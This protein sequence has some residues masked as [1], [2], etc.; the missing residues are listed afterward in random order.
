MSHSWRDDV[1]GGT[2]HP[3]DPAAKGNEG[4]RK[5][6]VLL[7]DGEDTVGDPV[8]FDRGTACKAAKD[9]GTEIFVV[10]AMH[11]DNVAGTLGD[12]LKACSS[13]ADNPEGTYVFLENRDEAALRRA[14]ASIAAQ[15]VTLRRTN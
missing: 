4:T 9:E 13:A 1:W 5:A 8:G 2:T 14:F 7:T 15:L 12:S 11:P 6:I 10:A 3:L